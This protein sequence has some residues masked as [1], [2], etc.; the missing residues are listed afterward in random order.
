MI[1]FE[2]KVKPMKKTNTFLHGSG[3]YAETCQTPMME[4]FRGN[5]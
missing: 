1:I 3:A 2:K 4:L 5:R